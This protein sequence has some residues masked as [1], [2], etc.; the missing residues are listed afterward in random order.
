MAGSIFTGGQIK[1]L[2]VSWEYITSLVP[3]HGWLSNV[4]KYIRYNEM[5]G[6]TRHGCGKG[7]LEL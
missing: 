6:N 5:L 4:T 3:H 7:N 2:G 1:Y